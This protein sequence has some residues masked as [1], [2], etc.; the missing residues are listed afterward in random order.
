MIDSV[1]AL[2][3]LGAG[4]IVGALITLAV[5]I[6]GRWEKPCEHNSVRRLNDD[7]WQCADCRQIDTL[8]RLK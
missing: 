1:T 7:W 8:G 2:M 4:A 5:W 3:S 6:P